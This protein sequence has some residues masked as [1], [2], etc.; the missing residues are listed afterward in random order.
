MF[1][2]IESRA[3]TNLSKV[4]V[5]AA[6]DRTQLVRLAYAL[7]V[8]VLVCVIYTLL[9]PK[10]L[11]TTVS[12][13]A[14]PWAEI[15]PPTRT[16]ISESRSR[17]CPGVSAGQQVTVEARVDGLPTDERVMLYYTTA[18]RQVVDKPI[19]MVVPPDSSKYRALLPSSDSSLQQTLF[20]RIEAGDATTRQFRVEVVAAPTIVVR[21]VTY[22]YPEYT[23]L[24][25]Q[26]IERQGDIKAIEGTEITLDALAN[27]DIQTAHVDFDC[28]GKFELR[29][30]PRRAKRR[31]L[32]TWR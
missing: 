10:V 30:Q 1:D 4:E 3:A 19:E 12:R 21:S 29:M 31:P 8:V 27:Q 24:I 9:S 18:D 17:T 7:L 6:V 14:M 15:E 11:W 13:V 25:T 20:Y 23:G 5:D 2:A 22:K 32:F 26:R 16:V 28:D